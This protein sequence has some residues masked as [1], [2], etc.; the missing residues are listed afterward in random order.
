MLSITALALFWP[1]EVASAGLPCAVSAALASLL[2][3]AGDL[4]M[5]AVP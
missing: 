1:S 3:V 4:P 2:A 5:A